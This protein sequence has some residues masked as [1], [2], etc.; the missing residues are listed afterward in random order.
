MNKKIL[1]CVLFLLLLDIVFAQE[2]IP[3]PE[4]IP[5]ERQESDGPSISEQN[6][7]ERKQQQQKTSSILYLILVIFSLAIGISSMVFMIKNPQRI[8]NLII[9][10][11][12]FLG[13]LI[14]FISIILMLIK[15]GKIQDYDIIE[16]GWPLVIPVLL[17]GY[18]TFNLIKKED[19]AERTKHAFGLSSGWIIFS[20]LA[21]ISLIIISFYFELDPLGVSIF[22]LLIFMI[23]IIGSFILGII[24]FIMDKYHTQ[25]L[26]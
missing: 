22:G 16:W 3:P 2:S 9:H 13:G 7:I 10:G 23:G 1:I 19:F 20:F 18:L 11:I 24:G 14:W 17:S 21:L 15:Y 4:Q 8:L 25:K 26:N 6:F 12:L 5:T